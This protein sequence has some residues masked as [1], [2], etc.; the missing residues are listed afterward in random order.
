MRKRLALALLAVVLLAA[1]Q[2][3]GAADWQLVIE[4]PSE[5]DAAAVRL[6]QVDVAAL[7]TALTRAGLALPPVVRVTLVPE[8]DPLAL[9]TPPWVVGQAFGTEA[10]VIFP[11]RVSS[12]PYDSLDSVMRHEV[13]HLA[14]SQQAGGQTL[15]RWFQE[16]VAVAVESGW[17]LTDDVRL[18]ID[19]LGGPALADVTRLFASES[20]P[21]NARAYRLA[22]ALVSDLRRRHGPAL[23]GAI[24]VHVAGGVPFRAAF[25]REAGE[26]PEIAAARTWRTYRRWTS[27]IPF[28]TST[29]VLWSGILILA[30]V[31]FGVRLRQRA[32]RR[33]A[34]DEEDA[35]GEGDGV[36]P[37]Q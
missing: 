7:D 33:R 29:G 23:P 35:A 19:T 31:A 25:E 13:V 4:R 26:S 17:G 1:P 32:L 20:Q 11:A 12:Y 30:F 36:G 22:A 8:D 18:A 10:I 16:G 37:F 24:A 5:L 27:W 6:Q 28:A 14:L 3:A 2:G 9:R 15:P 21:E 34:W